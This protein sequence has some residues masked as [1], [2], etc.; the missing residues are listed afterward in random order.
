[1]SVLSLNRV[2]YADTFLPDN[3]VFKGGNPE[4]IHPIVF[5]LYLIKTPDS[6]VLFDAGC[7]TMPD[8][9]MRNFIPPVK[10]LEK[11]GVLP[12]DVTDII[13]S[14][15]HHDHIEAVKDFKRA[16]IHI[17]KDEYACGKGYIPDGAKLNLF[18]EGT[19]V[20]GCIEVVNIGG[21]S[22]GSC[23]ALFD[24]EGKRY[25]I[26][27]DECYLRENLAKKIPTGSSHA[28]D[29]SAA[30]IEEYSKDKYVTLLCHD[31]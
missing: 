22:F 26:C 19:V 5:A 6:V 4:I 21:H 2:K 16:R 11:F 29:K 9:D 25:A 24:F 31:M 23:I 10:A 30:F 18:D 7:N 17:Q 14:H 28:P 13:I 27:G 20:G 3:V 12:D 15:A 1:M 8:F